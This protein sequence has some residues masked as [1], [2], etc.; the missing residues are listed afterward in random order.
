MRGYSLQHNRWLEFV[1]DSVE[2]IAWNAH[3]FESLVLPDNYKEMI[4][5]VSESQAE[6]RQSYDDVIQG[7]GRG[8]IL[9]VA[10]PPG[11]GKTLTA[12]AVAEQ[13]QVPLIKF[14]TSSAGSKLE[15][16]LSRV[17]ELAGRWKAILLLDEC[18]IF[19]EQRS[20]QDFERNTVVAMFLQKLEYYEGIL[21]MTTNRPDNID[22]AIRS[23]IHLT[24]QY[25]DLTSLAR[26][27]LWCNFLKDGDHSL[28]EAD[29]DELAEIDLNGR[30]IKNVIKIGHLLARRKLVPVN[31][32]ILKM[33]LDVEGINMEPRVQD[34]Q[35]NGKRCATS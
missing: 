1:V 35:Q 29:Y 28:G 11:V 24:M 5:A 2:D 18:D 7:K 14:K 15:E 22:P 21:F 9:L 33:V 16:A 12:E 34:D 31:R 17:L 13:M 8:V 19:L 30:Q 32:A 20:T 26:R 4:L 27:K 6:N 25:P 23:R 3:A 10:G